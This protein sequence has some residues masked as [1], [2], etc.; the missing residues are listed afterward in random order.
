MITAAG[1]LQSLYFQNLNS[2]VLVCVSSILQLILKKKEKK[3]FV[4]S[5]QKALCIFF[6]SSGPHTAFSAPFS[7][8]PRDPSIEVRTTYWSE[9]NCAFLFK[10]LWK[11]QLEPRLADISPFKPLRSRQLWKLFISTT[12]CPN[13]FYLTN[14]LVL[15]CSPRH[16]HFKVQ[17]ATRLFL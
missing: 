9:S 12:P 7:L 5:L 17:V 14:S 11:R 4:T 6:A 13:W 1:Y 8:W 2:L 16:I 3:F 15:F 10:I